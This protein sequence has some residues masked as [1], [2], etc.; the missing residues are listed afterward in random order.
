MSNKK[1]ASAERRKA[2]TSY[3]TQAIR[4]RQAVLGLSDEELARRSGLHVNSVRGILAR[5]K[6]REPGLAAMISLASGVG[7]KL[8]IGLVED[9][10]GELG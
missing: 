1:E 10:D 2:L 9:D 5:S 6:R 4:R 7:M 8:T 3:F